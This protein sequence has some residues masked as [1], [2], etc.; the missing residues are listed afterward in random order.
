MRY[1]N[2]CNV[3]RSKNQH[4]YEGSTYKFQ[5]R[6]GANSNVLYNSTKILF[7]FIIINSDIDHRIYTNGIFTKKT[8]D[9]ILGW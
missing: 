3:F 4:K 1:I 8:K 5:K 7:L 2:D 6:E 9:S